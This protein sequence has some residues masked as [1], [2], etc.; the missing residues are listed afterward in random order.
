MEIRRWGRHSE[1]EM[2]GITDKELDYVFV[3]LETQSISADVYRYYVEGLIV[4]YYTFDIQL[5]RK[6]IFEPVYLSKKDIYFLGE[7]EDKLYQRILENTVGI[8]RTKLM[9]FHIYLNGLK[10][11]EEEI[12]RPIIS[13]LVEVME[14][15]KYEKMLWCVTN[16][17]GE[18]GA[19]SG[20][21]KPLLQLFCSTNRCRQLLLGFSNNEYALL[22]MVNKSTILTM[23]ELT[24]ETCGIK[25]DS[26][27][28]T[29][30]RLLLYDADTNG[31][32]IYD[33]DS[34]Y[35]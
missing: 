29:Q 23:R 1:M 7:S 11:E 18:R 28:L 27:K 4:V 32:K 6:D 30:K 26:G 2:H 13:R 17:F 24:Y 14:K 12:F 15:I 21:Y 8:F 25:T 34:K 35:M 20:L 9:P 5:L 31:F 19:S 33:A 10:T 3:E 22:S 16:D